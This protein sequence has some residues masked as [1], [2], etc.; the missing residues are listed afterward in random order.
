[1]FEGK[2]VIV[3][4]W[5]AGVHFGTLVRQ[6][7]TEV[8][9]HDARRLWHWR[10][11]FSLSAVAVNGVGPDSKLACTVPQILLTEAIEIIPCTEASAAILRGLPTHA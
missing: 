2:E 5:S 9:L 11:A 1:M 4:T 7:G 10:G 6:D 3:R 8:V